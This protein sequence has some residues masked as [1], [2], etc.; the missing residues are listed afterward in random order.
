MDIKQEIDDVINITNR[1][2]ER[3]NNFKRLNMYERNPENLKK[4]LKRELCKNSVFRVKDAICSEGGYKIVVLCNSKI[5]ECKYVYAFDFKHHPL[6]EGDEKFMEGGTYEKLKKYNKILSIA[7]IYH[8][9]LYCGY[10]DRQRVDFLLMHH[11]GVELFH[12]LY[13]EQKKGVS[14]KP[15]TTANLW[16]CFVFLMTCLYSFGILHY[17]GYVHRDLKPENMLIGNSANNRN[18][19]MVSDYGFV[20]K[21]NSDNEYNVT[22]TSEYLTPKLAK[23]YQDMESSSTLFFKDL[24][25]HDLHTIGYNLI[26]MLL[27]QTY[28]NLQS[29]KHCGTVKYKCG[30]KSIKVNAKQRNTGTCEIEPMI[31]IA[32]GDGIDGTLGNRNDIVKIYE[33]YQQHQAMPSFPTELVEILKKYSVLLADFGFSS[34]FNNVSEAK[35]YAIDMFYEIAFTIVNNK[36]LYKHTREGLNSPKLKVK[37][38]PSIWKKVENLA[39]KISKK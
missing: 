10:K 31:F 17:H 9:K 22:G 16:L 37:L 11:N 2:F 6:E 30:A 25:E 33:K 29:N 15:K 35:E 4:R 38:N 7:P 18:F 12:F 13:G 27:L 1:L 26:Q 19:M 32:C 14:Y 34:H 39:N 21:E 24:I 3:Y 5:P 20:I 36:R 8:Q 28:D 23:I